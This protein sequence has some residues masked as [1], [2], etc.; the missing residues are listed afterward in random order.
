MI[1][2]SE[3]R[4]GD[5]LTLIDQANDGISFLIILKH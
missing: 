4:K 3:C 2:W 5:D 1:V